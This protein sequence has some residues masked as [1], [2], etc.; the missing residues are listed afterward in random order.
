MNTEIEN[1]GSRRE[2]LVDDTLLESYQGMHFNLH[3]AVPQEIV[4]T[5]DAPWEG[6][7]NGYQVIF[8]D[9]S[10][11]RMYYTSAR[12]FNEDGSVQNGRPIH[13]CYAESSD[14]I[15]W[16]RPN[17]GL[18]EF[19]GS[20]NNNI[21]YV[22]PMLDNLSVF[23]DTNPNCLPEERYKGFASNM[24]NKENYLESMVSPDGIHW[25]IKGTAFSRG[26]FDTLN[27]G[28][29]DE[30]RRQYWAYTRDF[31][32][33]EWRD[34]GESGLNGE[35]DAHGG[36]VRDIR[37]ST[38]QDFEKWTTPELLDFGDSP[39]YQL[40]TNMVT[41]YYRAPHIFIGFPTRYYERSW[42]PVFEELPDPQHRIQRK[43]M[44]ERYATAMTDGLFM[45]SR[46]GKTWNRWDDTPFIPN[47][48][49]RRHNWSYGD[50]YQCWGMIETPS[51][52]PYA[53]DE[54]SIYATEKCWKGADEL[55]RY[56]IRKDG[57]VSLHA[58]YPAC[59]LLTKPIIFQGSQLELN[60]STTV[61]G[62]IFVE[63]TGLDGNALP[64]YS[65]SDCDELVGDNL[66]RAV[67]WK[68][69]ADVSTLAGQPIRIRMT[70]R[71]ADLYAF[72]FTSK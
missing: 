63:I 4:M 38:S 33:R 26:A 69:S 22:R 46:N 50:C 57:F 34:T 14:G 12:V 44:S 43:K 48:I 32:Q 7:N 28:F 54:I 29:W 42:S 65:L 24:A 1:I 18:Y 41:P 70:L 31:H 27:L 3:P 45:T 66:D 60:Y 64:G 49:E 36:T 37:W 35:V 72:C 15:H 68:N 2:L 21:V 47:G 6:S 16:A 19:H 23:K 61:A 52:F 56:T 59:T 53:P 55:R 17:L 62:R 67:A 39:D 13:V 5:Y 25:S 51:M 11:I 20:R 30:S 9:G 10:I 58:G 71:E 8:R 40:Y